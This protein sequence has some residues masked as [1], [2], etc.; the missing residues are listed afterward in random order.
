MEMRRT[1]REVTERSAILEIIDRCDC[2]HLALM[3]DGYP[4]VIP[5]NFGFEDDGGRLVLYFHGAKEG[6]KLELIKNDGRAAFSMSCAHEMIPGKVACA[7]T[8]KYMSVCGRG[9]VSMVDGDERMHALSVIMAHYDR[10]NSHVFE[11][12]HAN[13]V[14]IFRMDVESFTGKSRQVK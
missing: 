4:Y 1:D 9:V 3:D 5:L 7:S 14:A 12:K 8:F 13:S 6:K 11:E 2:L 10:E